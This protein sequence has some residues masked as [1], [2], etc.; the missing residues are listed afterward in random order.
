MAKEIA[1]R[2]GSAA[3]ATAALMR[4]VFAA[5]GL[6]VGDRAHVAQA[7]VVS[8]LLH[9]AG[10]WLALSPAQSHKVQVQ[11]M[12]P[13]RRI[14]GHD[15][16]PPEGSKLPT[17]VETLVATGQAPV[18]AHIAVARLRLAARITLRGTPGIQ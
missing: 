2:C 18:Q 15:A 11:Y 9:G 13:L 5:R 16:L 6:P 10:T 7:C 4:R 14:A 8:R 3:S 1:Y 12:G 17:A